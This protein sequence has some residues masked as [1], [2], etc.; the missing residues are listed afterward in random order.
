VTALPSFSLARE[1]AAVWLRRFELHD[2]DAVDI[3]HNADLGA[4]IY[5]PN[6]ARIIPVVL[7]TSGDHG[8]ANETPDS[9]G[10]QVILETDV[11][12]LCARIVAQA[13]ANTYYQILLDAAS[14]E[15]AARFQLMESATQNAD[16]LSEELT[17]AVQAARRQ[18]I[19][20]QMQEL[21]VGAGL[22]NERSA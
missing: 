11:P 22:L 8:S 20:R 13:A 3:L 17:L 10:N 14:T 21:A 7:P 5:H 4:G 1:S 16:D 18:A 12:S 19:T 6:L 2:L 9:Q 15:H